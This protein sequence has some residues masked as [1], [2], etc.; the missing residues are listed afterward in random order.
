MNIRITSAA[1]RIASLCAVSVSTFTP[2]SAQVPSRL[3]G[4]TLDRSTR[5]LQVEAE[6]RAVIDTA[7]S[8]R[9]SEILSSEPHVAGTPRQRWTAEFVDSLGI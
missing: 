7:N 9:L 1:R 4:Y 2:L 8:R 5:Q 6:L 3:T